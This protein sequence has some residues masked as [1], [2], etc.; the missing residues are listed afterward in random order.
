MATLSRI[1]TNR[2]NG[3]INLLEQ[4]TVE[5]IDVFVDINKSILD[6]Y[7]IIYGPKGSHYEGGEYIGRIIHSPGYPLTPPDF[8]MLTPNGRFLTQEDEP[9]GTEKKI[10]LSNS[11]FHS[12]DWSPR[13]TVQGILRGFMSIMLDDEEHGIS[14]IVMTK[15]QRHKLALNSINYNK[16]HFKELYE[17]IKK[18]KIVATKNKQ[19]DDK[20]N[21]DKKKKDNKDKKN[22]IKKSKNKK[23][24]L[25]SRIYHSTIIDDKTLKYIM[26]NDPI[27]KS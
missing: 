27:F 14:H 3:D 17:K 24:T 21:E 16:T 10:C 23:E 4:E 19:Q 6:W 26:K 20:K 22:D 18:N 8:I 25:E 12:S 9:K 2:I 13:W 5:D 1:Q 7:F 11:G 15:E